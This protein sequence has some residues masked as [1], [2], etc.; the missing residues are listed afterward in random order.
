M[1][2][3][4]PIGVEGDAYRQTTIGAA[5]EGTREPRDLLSLHG[6]VKLAINELDA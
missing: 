6:N 4:L 2:L 3:A 1:G 5:K